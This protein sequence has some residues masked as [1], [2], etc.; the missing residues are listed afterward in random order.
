MERAKGKVTKEKER[1]KEN[2][3]EKAKEMWQ[4]PMQANSAAVVGSIQAAYPHGASDFRKDA[5][6]KCGI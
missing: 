2:P 4:I 6:I 3:T 5:G 1:T